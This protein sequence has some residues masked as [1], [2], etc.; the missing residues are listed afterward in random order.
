MTP[1]RIGGLLLLLL[2]LILTATAVQAATATTEQE[3][4]NTPAQANRLSIYS[5]MEGAID[6]AGDVDYFKVRGV[7]DMW[8]IV[9][10]LDTG[11]STSSQ[12]GVLTAYAPDG[13]TELQH[14]QAAS[15]RKGLIAWQYFTGNEDH[16]LRV[17]EAGDDQTISQYSL[18]YY[19]LAI[20]HRGNEKAEQEPND[21]L[22]TATTSALVNRGVIS[23]ASDRDCYVVYAEE[24]KRFLYV[25]NADPEGDGGADFKLKL[26]R[27]DG[28][29]WRHADRA[30]AGGHEYIDEVTIPADGV[31]TYCVEA[32]SGAGPGAT[33]LAGP[34]VNTRNYFPSFQAA[35]HW[36][37][38]HPGNFARVG[39]D[40]RYTMTFIHTSPLRI[41]EEF[42]LRIYYNP[43]CQSIVNVPHPDFQ[44]SDAFEWRYDGIAPNMTVTKSFVLRAEKPCVD[45]VKL[46]LSI[47]Y[48]IT[49]W[50]YGS[51][52]VIGEGYY[53]PLVMK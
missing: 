43:D 27:P 8:G 14:N 52:Y 47:A 48:Y 23:S 30:G 26:Y 18:H 28:S 50:G 37:N 7:G 9:A 38:A 4:N 24:G 22:A 44:Y 20:G 13:V 40:M 49:G 32:K 45:D 3:P 53:L 46:N 33:Y 6:P 29:S 36:D 34:I 11:D 10:F 1:K 35:I 31:Y 41:P 2:F 21:T 42:R 39:E 17:S 51:D 12:Q 15:E 16:F 19:P 25:L 5:P